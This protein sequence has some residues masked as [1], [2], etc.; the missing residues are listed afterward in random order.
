MGINKD[1]AVVD[2]CLANVTYSLV[3]EEKEL[4]LLGGFVGHNTA[5]I[6]NSCY[7]TNLDLY[8]AGHSVVFTEIVKLDSETIKT[9]SALLSNKFYDDGYPHLLIE[10]EGK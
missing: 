6:K 10:K 5:A 9:A 4:T 7:L 2:S 3:E 1:L 8:S